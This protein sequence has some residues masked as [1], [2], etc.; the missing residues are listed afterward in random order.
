VTEAKAA[1]ARAK[2]GVEQAEKT[3]VSAENKAKAASVSLAKSD[4][5]LTDSL[6]ELA[7]ART[8]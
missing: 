3:L 4:A 2:A 6:K 7:A 8:K 5:A 1:E